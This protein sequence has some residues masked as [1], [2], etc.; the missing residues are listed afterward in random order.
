MLQIKYC[1]CRLPLGSD[2]NAWCQLYGV[3][4][5]SVSVSKEIHL[6]GEP[7]LEESQA[8][9]L[10]AMK[11]SEGKQVVLTNKA[12]AACCRKWCESTGPGKIKK[13]L[14]DARSVQPQNSKCQKEWKEK[15]TALH[16]ARLLLDASCYSLDINRSLKAER[17]REERWTPVSLFTQKKERAPA[18]TQ[19]V[20]GSVWAQCLEMAWDFFTVSVGFH[21]IVTEAIEMLGGGGLKRSCSP[22]TCT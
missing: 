3:F 10:S 5:S 20:P 19:W 6:A 2:G 4:L 15:A 21:V 17:R 8:K 9:A 12:F 11:S 18:F 13:L 7:V 1:Y 14:G 22:T 16:A